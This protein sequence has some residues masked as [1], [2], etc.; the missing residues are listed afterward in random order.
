MDSF[1]FRTPP[2]FFCRKIIFVAWCGITIITH[3]FLVW[4]LPPSRRLECSLP[5]EDRNVSNSVLHTGEM[6][7][8]FVRILPHVQSFF[9][10][11]PRDL[12][13]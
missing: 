10:G 7:A 4:L 3:E 13:H 12:Y 11:F 9:S 6:K 8:E 5:A 1:L 2:F